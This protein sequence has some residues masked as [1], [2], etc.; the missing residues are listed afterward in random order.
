[1]PTFLV[2][3][4][5]VIFTGC[6][7]QPAKQRSTNLPHGNNVEYRYG[8]KI[9]TQRFVERDEIRY[10]L[11]E[12]KL[13]AP[14]SVNSRTE[15]D[16]WFEVGA[17]AE[18]KLSHR[19]PAKLVIDINHEIVS[20]KRWHFPPPRSSDDLDKPNAGFTLTVI[21]DGHP[22]ELTPAHQIGLTKD[23]PSDRT[24]YES[25][26]SELPLADFLTIAN[27]Q[28]VTIQLTSKVKFDLDA[29]TRQGLKYF[30][31]TVN[32]IEPWEK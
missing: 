28:S 5:L 24:F 16:H 22:F 6:G 9:L 21:A 18:S 20:R 12:L 4:C 29:N 32:D 30:A 3:L 13:Q 31:E 10:A 26:I 23:L 27:A 25:Y 19:P 8:A 1:M 14:L 17:T 7:I 11:S 15:A 2:A